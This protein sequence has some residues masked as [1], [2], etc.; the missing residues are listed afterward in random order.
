MKREYRKTKLSLKEFI[1]AY[2]DSFDLEEEQSNRFYVERIIE[3]EFELIEH[4]DILSILKLHDEGKV[5][6]YAPVEDWINFLNGRRSNGVL[7]RVSN[8]PHKESHRFDFIIDFIHEEFYS[9]SMRYE[10][11]Q[12]VSL[13]ELTVY[14]KK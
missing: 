6:E 5:Y 4:R 7:C 2:A 14:F 1:S 3:G 8:S 9:E 13:E 10:Y 12:P 11:A